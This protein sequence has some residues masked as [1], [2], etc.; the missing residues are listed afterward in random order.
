[1]GEDWRVD[2]IGAARRQLKRKIEEGV[3]GRS[4]IADS[5]VATFADADQDARL[6]LQIAVESRDPLPG[7]CQHRGN[8]IG[9]QAAGIFFTAIIGAVVI[10]VLA[11]LL[12]QRRQTLVPSAP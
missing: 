12:L 3:A 1:M 8:A 10:L 7:L 4:G 6:R 9:L 2:R 5:L 11:S